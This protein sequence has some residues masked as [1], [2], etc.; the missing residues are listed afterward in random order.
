MKRVSV[1]RVILACLA[2][3]AIGV[4]VTA[5]VNL[6]V[7]GTNLAWTIVAVGLSSLL[8]GAAGAAIG[9]RQKPKGPAA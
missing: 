9:A 3:L 7:P 2:G 5:I 1:L 4:I 8:S 6:V